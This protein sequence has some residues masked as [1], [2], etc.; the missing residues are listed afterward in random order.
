[1]RSMRLA[2]VLVTLVVVA[3]A[4]STAATTAP[5]Q[6]PASQ[7]AAQSAAAPSAAAPSTA[8]STAPGGSPLSGT[9]TIWEAYGASGVAE[10]D[11]FDQ[12][13]SNVLAANPGL[14]V[15]DVDVPFN[16]LFTKFET[17]AASSGVPDLYIAPNDSM[18]KEARAGLL[19]D[20]TSLLPQLTNIS[21]A[22]IKADTVDGKLYAIP[23]SIKGV[24]LFYNTALLPTPPATTADWL[25]NASKLGWVYGANGGGAYY[26]WGLFQAFGGSILDPNTGKCAATANSGVA[27]AL[28][29]LQQAKAAGMHMYQNDNLAKADLIS[30][31]LAGFIDGPWQTG[32]LQKALGSKLAVTPGPTGPKGPFGPLVAPDGYYINANSSNAD[33]AIQFALQMDSQANEQIFADKAG[34]IPAISGVTFNNPISQGFANAYKTGFPRP[35]AKQLDNYWTPFGNALAAVID[36]GTAPASAVATACQ[37][38]DKANGF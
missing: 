1:M 22:A 9:L 6:A 20:L 30:G 32:D 3:G 23:E 37:Q 38:M 21:P 2:S 34:H 12:I 31:K 25:K 35:T 14:K 36:K 24:A 29:W 19:K 4:C 28:A 5:T 16:N 33:L 7:A 17:S 13:L 18:A 8:A 15:T 10:K 26:L 11:A 27:D